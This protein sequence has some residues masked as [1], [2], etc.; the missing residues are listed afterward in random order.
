LN[1]GARERSLL[2]RS[3]DGLGGAEEAIGGRSPRK[4]SEIVTFLRDVSPVVALYWALSTSRWRFRRRILL[5]LTRLIKVKPMLSGSDILAMGYSEGPRV[6]EILDTL[7]LAR[8][9]GA[10][11]TRDDEI[12]WVTRNFKREVEMEGR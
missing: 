10:V 3:V 11:D 7:L 4:N 8:L 1:L 2:R 12:A 5:Y 6:G 9:D